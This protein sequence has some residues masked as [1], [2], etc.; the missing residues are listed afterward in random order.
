M[1]LE[2]AAI[3]WVVDVI[4]LPVKAFGTIVHKN[5][6]LIQSLVTRGGALPDVAMSDDPTILWCRRDSG[7]LCPAGLSTYG[8]LCW[9]KEK[10][11]SCDDHY[12]IKQLN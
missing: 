10:W 9:K 8:N 4:S 1:S 5:E 12:T 7:S 3:G 2:H 6:L 11:D